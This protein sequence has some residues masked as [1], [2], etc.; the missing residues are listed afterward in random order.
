[1]EQIKVKRIVANFETPD[2]GLAKLFY[3]DV[4]TCPL[5]NAHPD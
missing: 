1:M 5:L 4:L 3:G 2:L